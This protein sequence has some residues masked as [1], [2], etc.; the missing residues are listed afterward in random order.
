M[1]FIRIHHE[2]S[3]QMLRHVYEKIE[4]KKTEQK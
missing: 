1:A 4:K 2:K 3:G